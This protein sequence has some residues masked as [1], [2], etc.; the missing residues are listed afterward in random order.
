ML[1]P[2]DGRATRLSG[3][4]LL[5]EIAAGGPTMRR[6]LMAPLCSAFVIP[7]LGQAIN[8][9][10]KKAAMLLAGVLV[11]LVAGVTWLVRVLN[12]LAAAP[13][14]LPHN[15]AALNERLTPAD[16]RLLQV[17]VAV[18]AALWVY[19]VADAYVHGRRRDRERHST[20]AP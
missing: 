3:L 17:L 1:A 2:K 11:V 19:S 8:Q 9:Q 20:P 13:A 7:G 18:F 5:R 15:A 16:V 10:L 6:S 12:R 4:P 14:D